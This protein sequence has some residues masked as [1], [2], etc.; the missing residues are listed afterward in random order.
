MPE[1]APARQRFTFL[2]EVIPDAV[3]AVLASYLTLLGFFLASA[4]DRQ[5]Q[6]N[7]VFFQMHLAV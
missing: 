5:S 7:E 3:G 2:P 6:G 1:T 4:G